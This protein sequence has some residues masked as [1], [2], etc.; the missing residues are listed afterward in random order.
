MCDYNAISY[1]LLAGKSTGKMRDYPDALLLWSL[2]LEW[3]RYCKHPMLAVLKDDFA[4]GNEELGEVS[5]SEF[6]KGVKAGSVSS[7]ADSMSR[8][9]RLQGA[10]RDAVRSFHD[11]LELSQEGNYHEV[12]SQIHLAEVNAAEETL[13]ELRKGLHT[14]HPRGY[15]YFELEVSTSSSGKKSGRKVP[16]QTVPVKKTSLTPFFEQPPP[17]FKWDLAADFATVKGRYF[18]QPPRQPTVAR[19]SDSDDSDAEEVA[20]APRPIVPVV[21]RSAANVPPAAARGAAG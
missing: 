14:H 19:D 12:A 8:E 18:N 7:D 9:Y 16:P 5:L 6:S 1:F 21:T 2:Q 4:L 13:K 17:G 20:P 11:S 10:G 15:D 3:M